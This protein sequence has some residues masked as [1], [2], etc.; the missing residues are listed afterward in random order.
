MGAK[1]ALAVLLGVLT[2]ASTLA[3]GPPSPATAATTRISSWSTDRGSVEHSSAA[4]AVFWRGSWAT[5]Q[6]RLNPNVPGWAR[7]GFAGQSV[8]QVVRL[9]VGGSHVRIRLSNLY[10][11]TTLRLTGATIARAGAGAAVKRG[12][13]R[14]LAFG[15]HAWARIPH[16]GELDSDR[17]AMR[18]SALEKVTVTLYF[19]RRTGPATYHS[20]AMAT[21]YRATG[22]HRV[23]PTGRAFTQT[24][25]SWYYLTRIDV[26]GAQAQPRNGIVALGDSITDGYSSTL[27]ANRRFPDRLAERLVRN[28]TPRPVLN[29]GIS[30]NRLLSASPCGGESATARFRRD[31]V[32]QPGVH[33]AIILEGINDIRTQGSTSGCGQGAPHITAQRLING[34]RN[35]I[36]WAHQR[37]LK[38]IGATLL[39]C[40][41]VDG[42]EAMRTAVN[43]WIRSTPPGR[44]GYD[45]VADLDRALRNPNRPG[46]LLPRYDSG[47]HIHPNDAG[48]QR[49]AQ[50][51]PLT[52]L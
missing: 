2:A 24:S 45:A 37:G 43:R 27:N 33:T 1:K 19:A 6:Q 50:A 23:D 7:R 41:C 29:A 25:R 5:A 52:R 31:V 48:Y 21:S 17:L 9:S 4:G 14:N 47:D 32:L 11:N 15:G 10:G 42:N 16:G 51:I 22:D 13:Q 26:R 39:P 35:L 30:A 28:R 12:S 36:K 3:A 46:T 44:G 8:R 40:S 18:T 49:M 38:V 34:H 20:Q